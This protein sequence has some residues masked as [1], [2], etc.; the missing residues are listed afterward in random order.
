M[1]FE[2]R[3]AWSA[4]VSG[5]VAFFLWGHPIWRNTATG[6]Y[7]GADGLALWAWDVIRLIGGGVVL[8]L[9][10]LFLFHI[11]YA[12]ATRQSKLQFLTDE[13]DKRIGNRA[14]TVSLVVTS[15]AILL[16]IV[17]LAAGQSAL[18]ALNTILVGMALAAL[19]SE[20]WRIAIYR[21]GA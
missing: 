14:A 5:I 2:E 13:R 15:S 17:L 16:A 9:V 4:V 8:A 20:L 10:M 3:G 12:V 19:G 1:S 11:A 18:A 21:L 6:I 7:E